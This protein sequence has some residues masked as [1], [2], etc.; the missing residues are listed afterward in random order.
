MPRPMSAPML[1]ALQASE[2]FPAIFVQAQFAT[3]TLYLW[4][5]VG[6]KVWNGNTYLGMGTFGS[7]SA[8]E[9]GASVEAKGIV[10]SLSGI[11]PT[12]LA[13]ALQQIK[14]GLPVTVFLAL[15]DN[16]GALIADPLTSWAG[17]M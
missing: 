4:S 8:I 2:L 1:A 5:G 9:E 10:L 14:L 7:V 16:T 13:D 11:D 6:P 15:F 12:M 3:S 17:R